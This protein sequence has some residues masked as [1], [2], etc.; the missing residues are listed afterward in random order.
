MTVDGEASNGDNDVIGHIVCY[1]KC[2][3]D[4]GTALIY[5]LSWSLLITLARRRHRSTT[6]RQVTGDIIINANIVT[7]EAATIATLYCA[8]YKIY[9]TRHGC[10]VSGIDVT[11]RCWKERLR[12]LIAIMRLP[13]FGYHVIMDDVQTGECWYSTLRHRLSP[14]NV[15]GERHWSLARAP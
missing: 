13:Q 8:G 12:W 9:A 2:R 5:Y 4:I 3:D 14:F 1:G 11:R 6:L 7:L 10:L 15:M